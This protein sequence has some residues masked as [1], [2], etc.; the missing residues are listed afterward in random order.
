MFEIL[1]K[2]I[3]VW[4]MLVYVAAFA[5]GYHTKA[6]VKAIKKWNESTL[7]NETY[8]HVLPSGAIV[9]DLKITKVP[10]YTKR[11]QEGYQPEEDTLDRT[12]PPQQGSCLPN[13][14]GEDGWRKQQ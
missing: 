13:R 4:H 2:E 14:K 9:T 3:Y 10:L 8:E 7:Y 5:I 12:N 11:F 6:I 1:Y